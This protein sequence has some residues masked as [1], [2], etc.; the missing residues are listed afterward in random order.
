MVKVKKISD[1]EKKRWYISVGKP[2]MMISEGTHR[3]EDAPDGERIYLAALVD[4]EGYVGIRG[5]T[6][7]IHVGMKSLLPY[8]L[9]K[10]Y[11]GRIYK[12]WK[13]RKG[14]ESLMYE[15]DVGKP[16]RLRP[17]IVSIMPFSRIKR[18]QLELLLEAVDMKIEYRYKKKPEGFRQRLLEIK[19]LLS[20][21]HHVNPPDKEEVPYHRKGAKTLTKRIREL[22][23]ENPDIK[24]KEICKRLDLPHKEKQYSVS[25][26][27]SKIRRG[28]K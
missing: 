8:W 9:C 21:L 5:M 6:P 25:S 3:I 23:L 13:G 19:K 20:E 11:G 2:P 18:Q 4:G 16:K 26:I 10:K 24:A 28:K 27:L 14:A 15:W 17:F 7:E 1:S 22:W 12:R